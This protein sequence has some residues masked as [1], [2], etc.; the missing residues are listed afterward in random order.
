MTRH[1]PVLLDEICKALRPEE[2]Q[3]YID[4]TFGAG[5]YSQALLNAANCSVIAIDRDPNAIKG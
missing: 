5:G 4:A 2:G 3:V 1:V